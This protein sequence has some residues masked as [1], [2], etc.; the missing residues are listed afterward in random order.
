MV[1]MLAG[2]FVGAQT[3]KID[4]LMRLL[5]GM[6]EDTAKVMLLC[7]IGE[8]FEDTDPETAKR[9]LRQAASL[10]KKLQYPEGE[11][12]Y[13][14]CYGGVCLVQGQFDSSIY[15]NQLALARAQTLKDQVKIGLCLFNIGIGYREKAAFHK[16]VDYLLQG[17]KILEQVNKPAIVM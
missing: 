2:K 17:R 5:P 10:N 15:Y 7:S 1:L 16:A 4:S 9:Y 3:N 14:H 13:L 6:K 11:F 12:R 8:A